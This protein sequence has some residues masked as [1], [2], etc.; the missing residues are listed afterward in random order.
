MRTIGSMDSAKWTSG[1]KRTVSNANGDPANVRT[2]EE[3]YSIHLYEIQPG[4]SSGD[5]PI[6]KTRE[7]GTEETDRDVSSAYADGSCR[8]IPT[9]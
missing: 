9:A 6:R 8:A 1:S 7:R 3:P 5:R 2:T 4:R